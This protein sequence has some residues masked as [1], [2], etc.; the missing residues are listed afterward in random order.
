MFGVKPMGEVIRR[1]REQRIERTALYFW[2]W[3]RPYS[4][5]K[6]RERF[7]AFL[8]AL[9]LGR[10]ENSRELA[11]YFQNL[12]DPTSR[13]PRVRDQY[14]WEKKQE[15]LRAFFRDE[16]GWEVRVR[17]WIASFDE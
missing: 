1:R 10:T 12:M 15:W 5:D 16:P 14:W 8:N 6:D 2:K 11:E 17:A 3:N 4:R 9:V 13:Y 7:V